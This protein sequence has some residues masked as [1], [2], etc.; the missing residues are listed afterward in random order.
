MVSYQIWN[1]SIFAYTISSHILIV[2]LTLGLSLLILISEFIALRYKNK[3]YEALAHKMSIA[4]VINFAFGTASGV[5]MAVELFLF[6]PEFM[7]VVGDVAMGTF[8]AEVFA[9]LVESISLVT[10]VYF[11][12]N[13]RNRWHHWLVSI[14][15]LLGTGAS[16]ALIV[17]VNA[18]MNTPTG[19]FNIPHYL[20][21]GKII[22]V[23]PLKVFWEPSTFAQQFHMYA[24]EYLAGSMMILVYLAYK[25][26]KTRDIE[27]KKVYMAGI[28][29]LSVI[30]IIDIII[31]GIAGSNE[32]TTLMAVEPLKYASLEQNMVPTNYGAPE[33]I[34][35]LIINGKEAYY[36][37]LPLAQSLLAYPLTLG[38][39]AIPGLSS[40]P[41]SSWSPSVSHDFLDLMVG[42]G[43]LIGLFWL[44]VVIQ[45]FRK[46]NPMN[47]KKTLWATIL[48]GIIAV[49]TMEDGWW[50]AEVGR[51]PYVIRSP[52]PGG[53]IVNGVKYYGVMDISQATSYSPYVWT[54]GIAVII[55][56]LII[57]PLM[58]Y[59]M[60]KV[61]NIP[62]INSEL[63]KADSE[64]NEKKVTGIKA[65]MR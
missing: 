43:V 60:A 49:L 14:G 2:T 46:K 42:A 24:A 7:R 20:E 54:I 56:Y 12:D 6:W 57:E 39:G 61:L 23:N 64:V 17:N 34:F 15:I 58:F 25:Y 51:A 10:Y 4:L 35:G 31:T 8:Y 62:D 29:I 40:Y 11:W 50:T 48:F 44:Y 55:F 19:S 52:V 45:Y 21:T 18:W 9:F 26:M 36:I 32:L 3:Y 13:F 30:S 5:F 38:H 28:S 37:N 27:A 22:D 33:H 65:G 59:Y 53:I 47:D 41:A 1:A 16:A 63:N